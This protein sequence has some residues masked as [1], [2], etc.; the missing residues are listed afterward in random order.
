MEDLNQK[1][2]I[3]SRYELDLQLQ[4]L[5]ELQ[6]ALDDLGI[7]FRLGGGTLLGIVRDRKLIPWDWDLEVNLLVEQV[8]LRRITVE[9]SLR[10]AGFSVLRANRTMINFKFKLEKYG[11]VYEV[12]AWQRIGGH[13]YRRHYRLPVGLFH[14]IGAVDLDGHVFPTFADPDAYLTYQYG[15]WRTP[16]RTA[17]KSVYLLSGYRRGP[18]AVVRWAGW[19]KGWIWRIANSVVRRISGDSSNEQK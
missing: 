13:R 4:G 9:Q 15:D 6:Q 3:R 10:A 11:A 5:V 19:A 18:V 16:V 17:D 12:R 1:V 7:P 14:G 8:F 2:R